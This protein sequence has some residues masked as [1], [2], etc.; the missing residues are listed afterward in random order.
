MALSQRWLPVKLHPESSPTPFPSSRIVLVYGVNDGV[1]EVNWQ[2]GHG[3]ARP[4]D[5]CWGCEGFLPDAA[6]AVS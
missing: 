1:F 5:R 3:W 4:G 6:T 2:C